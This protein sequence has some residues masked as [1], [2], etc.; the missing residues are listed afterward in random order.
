MTKVAFLGLGAM[1][2]RMAKNILEAGFELTVWNRTA[3]A[4]EPLVKSGARQAASPKEAAEGAEIVVAMVTD[5]DVSREVWTNETTGALT[6]MKAGSVA[7]EMSTLTPAWVAALK[8]KAKSRGVALVDAPVSGSLPQ[9]EGKLLVVMAGGDAETFE[10]VKPVLSATGPAH[11][12]GASGQ[13]ATLK[14]AV[15]ALMGIQ[16]TAWAEMLSFLGKQGLDAKKT[17]E[18]LSTMAICSPNAAANSKLMLAHD[19][20]PRFPNALL[21]KDFRYLKQTAE[22]SSTPI[23]DAASEVFQRAAKEM[24]KENMTAVI[25]F[26]E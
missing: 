24:G 23:A 14:L 12:I 13:G 10:K 25:R 16:L 9:A 18:L 26:Y 19:F 8:A 20:A 17:L 11:H 3:S 22:G 7:V 5:D 2:V 15:N 1:G 21:A 6:G 4:A